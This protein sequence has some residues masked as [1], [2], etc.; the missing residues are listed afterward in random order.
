MVE[1]LDTLAAKVEALHAGQTKIEV[2]LEKIS[3]AISRIA[4]IEER[5]AQSSRAID[6]IANVIDALEQRISMLERSS[7]RLKDTKRWVDRAVTALVT[8]V[9]VYAAHNI[10]L[11]I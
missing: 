9:A 1:T 7:D 3:D 8:A 4:V 10:G 11:P 5:Q 6:R 2:A